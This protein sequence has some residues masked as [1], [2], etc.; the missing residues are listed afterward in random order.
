MDEPCQIFFEEF[1]RRTDDVP[2]RVMA[3]GMELEDA[4]HEAYEETADILVAEHGYDDDEAL[5]LAKV[6][7][8]SVKKWLDEGDLDMDELRERLE[9]S[10]QEWELAEDLSA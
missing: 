4:A 2:E 7:A 9:V 1:R 6:F 8:R 5:A 10:Q 3:R